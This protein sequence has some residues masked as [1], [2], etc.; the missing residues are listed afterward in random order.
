MAANSAGISLGEILSDGLDATKTNELLEATVG[1]LKEIADRSE[2]KVVQQQLANIFGVT[3]ADLKAIGNLANDGK[4]VKNI[5]KNKLDYK[6]MVGETVARSLTMATRTSMGEMLA[7]VWDN[8]QYSLAAG[9]AANPVSYLLFKMS[10][11]LEESTGGID[12]PFL[13]VYGFGVDLN[14]SVAQLMQ[15]ASMAGGLMGTLGTMMGGL[16]NTGTDFL[17]AMGAS[18]DGKLVSRGTGE[19]TAATSGAGA[20]ASGLVGNGSGADM[21]AATMAQAADDIASIGQKGKEE[22]EDATRDDIIEVLKMLFG[23][24]GM[25]I[26]LTTAAVKLGAIKIAGGNVDMEALDGFTKVDVTTTK[27]AALNM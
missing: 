25:K 16:A 21:Q 26:D 20:S 12:L 19:T 7:N 2:S 24:L 9:M 15:I 3:A 23:D 8:V 5:A 14:T 27:K 13:N 11:L 6:G 4:T 17:S 10:N 1:Y 22:N 18:A